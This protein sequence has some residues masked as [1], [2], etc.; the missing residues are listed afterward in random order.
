VRYLQIEAVDDTSDW[1]ET[2]D[3]DEV[4]EAIN[5]FCASSNRKGLAGCTDVAQFLHDR[6]FP[7]VRVRLSNYTTHGGKNTTDSFFLAIHSQEDSGSDG[8]VMVPLP[9]TTN[10]G[11]VSGHSD[12]RF[13]FTCSTAV[14]MRSHR[15]SGA[16]EGHQGFQD[17]TTHEETQRFADAAALVTSSLCSG[18]AFATRASIPRLFAEG[19]LRTLLKSVWS[20]KV[21]GVQVTIR[22]SELDDDFETKAVA[23]QD[24]EDTDVQRSGPSAT[25]NHT[26]TVDHG[27]DSDTGTRPETPSEPGSTSGTERSQLGDSL[28]RPSVS[29]STSDGA[30]FREDEISA[31]SSTARP[32]WAKTIVQ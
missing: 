19:I 4:F 16:Q 10:T 3:E 8:I 29:P 32:K 15:E 11:R 6:Y 26:H 7:R 23:T 12:D 2:V 9:K 18:M 31:A 21:V 25:G 22:S 20:V 17:L 24:S 1:Q 30:H 14:Q 5:V 27:D 13:A 28:T